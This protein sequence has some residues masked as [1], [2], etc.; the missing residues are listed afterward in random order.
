MAKINFQTYLNYY[1]FRNYALSLLII[2]IFKNKIIIIVFINLTFW[3]F[4]IV[5][6]L[7]LYFEIWPF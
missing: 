6:N 4:F 3:Y 1:I 2:I 7:K 5:F